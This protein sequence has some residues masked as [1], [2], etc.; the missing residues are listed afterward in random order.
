M[1][2]N[3]KLRSEPPGKLVGGSSTISTYEAECCYSR[4]ERLVTCDHG[5]FGATERFYNC[6]A[7]Y[8][9]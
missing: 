6:V 7:L 5:N 4:I 2:V 9:N 3:L 1:H 8:H